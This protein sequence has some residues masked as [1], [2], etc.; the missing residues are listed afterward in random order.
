MNKKKLLTA[1]IVFT[2]VITSCNTMPKNGNDN[3]IENFSS[4]EETVVVNVTDNDELLPEKDDDL[5]IESG[6]D[7]EEET[8]N[9][10]KEQSQLS[11]DISST[12]GEN[13]DSNEVKEN[14]D[15]NLVTTD[16]KESGKNEN[17]GSNTDST[18]DNNKLT[19]ENKTEESPKTVIKIEE[20]DEYMYVSSSVN[21]REGPSVDNKKIGTLSVDEKVHVTG[22][23]ADGWV[24]IEYQNGEGYVNSGFLYDQAA[25]DKKKEDEEAALLRAQEEAKAEAERQTE[26]QR[27]AEEERR[28]EEERQAE[29]ER[30]LQQQQQT[31]DTSSFASRVVELCNE[32]R[33]ANGLSPL[34]ED[35]TLDSLAGIRAGEILTLFDHTRPDGSSCFTVFNGVDFRAAGE[36][37]AAGQ[38]SPEEVVNDWMNSEGHRANILSSDFGK[39]GVAYSV[40]GQYGTGWVQL[41]TN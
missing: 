27:Q 23:T 25:Y 36:N 37:I 24:R 17:A 16:E 39:I 41:F 33:I 11:D 29:E 38:T 20:T 4:N 10:S 14:T 35:A 5:L 13:S 15:S 18:A 3:N 2:L 21:V 26:L 12:A 22:K 8:N 7:S 6:N 40:G 30:L 9:E 1:L 19:E 34:T 32:Q 31:T 28:A